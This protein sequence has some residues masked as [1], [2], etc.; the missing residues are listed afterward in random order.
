M[1]FESIITAGAILSGFCG[2][3][4]TFRIQREA[5]YYRQPVLDFVTTSARDVKIGLTHFTAPFL[6]LILTT[7]ISLLFG[8]VIPVLGMVGV[9]NILVSER[10]VVGGLLAAVVFIAGYF[11]AE[12]I[13]YEIISTML[14]HDIA[15]WRKNRIVVLASAVA[16]VLV[17][18][19]AVVCL[20]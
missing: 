2:S 13:H 7:T 5:A 19:A 9:R 16:S 18:W 3:F 8:V 14:P 15:E 1:F 10:C 17:F 11:L 6:I 4:L 20:R 12:L